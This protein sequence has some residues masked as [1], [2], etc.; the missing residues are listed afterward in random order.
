M[1]YQLAEATMNDEQLERLVMAILQ[2]IQSPVLVMVT[3]AEGYRHIIRRRLAASGQTLHLA[4]DEGIADA[5][6]WQSMGN[7]LPASAWREALPTT[8]YRAVVLPFLDYPL[9]AQLV[10][11][12]LHSPVARWLHN[13][14]LAGI[15]VLA[16]RYHCDPASELNQLRGAVASSA[17]GE[18]IQAILSQLA[19][20][21]ITLCSM[22]ELLGKLATAPETAKPLAIPRRYL[23][24][25]DVV[26]NPALATAPDALLTDAAID[27]L[28]N[29]KI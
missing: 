12:S 3:A 26:N 8:A 6:E 20:C 18:K 13:V 14:L 5:A 4:L 29:R 1:A 25:T 17:Y 2:R 19:A 16:L 23:T 7:V 11:G 15:P 10:N 27:F 24:V 22:N 9:A 28:K 21:G